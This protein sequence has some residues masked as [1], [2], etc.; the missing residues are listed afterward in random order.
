LPRRP[1]QRKREENMTDSP[2]AE[3]EELLRSAEKTL[4]DRRLAQAVALGSKAPNRLIA[5]L[6]R[7]HMA[8]VAIQTILGATRQL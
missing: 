4:I 5:N 8:I 3:I 1:G 6:A 7:T 2:K